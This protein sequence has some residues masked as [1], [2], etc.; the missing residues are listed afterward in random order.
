MF[1]FKS[2]KNSKKNSIKSKTSKKTIKNTST[3]TSTSTRTIT[4]ASN[5]TSNSTNKLDKYR[6]PVNKDITKIKYWE[7]PNR[8]HFHNWILDN[9]SQ[10]EIS[11]TKNNKNKYIP[12]LQQHFTLTNF[13][14]IARDYLQDESPVRGVFLY[15]GLGSGKT[16]TGI[17]ISEAILS[18]KKVVIFSK[19][20]LEANWIKEIRDC[21]ADYVKNHNY[22]VFIKVNIDDL[23]TTSLENKKNRS[24]SRDNSYSNSRGGGDSSRGGGDSSRGSDSS[25]N[26]DNND[27]N[28]TSDNIL[29]LIDELGIPHSI[30]KANGC[31]CLVDFT[32]TT[33]NFNDLTSDE[34]SKLDKQIESMVDERFEFLHTD[35]AI[36]A[37]LKPELLHNKIIIW[38][39]VHNLGN[40]MTAKSENAKKY[41]DMFMNAKNVKIMFLSGT[42]IINRIFEITKIYNILRGY[43]NVLQVQFK[44]TFDINIDYDKLQ[45]NLKKNKYIDQIIINKSKKSINISKNP[46][47]F[48]TSPDNKGILY[49]PDDNIDIDKFKED[50]TKIIQLLG[51]KFNITST[52]ETCFPEDEDTFEQLF[53]NSELNKIKHIDLIKKRI[54]GLTSYYDYQDPKNYPILLKPINIIQV[55]MSEYQFGTYEKFRHKEIEKDKQ[56]KRNSKNEDD[57]MSKSTFRIKSRLA[58]TF[59]FPEEIGNPYDSKTAEAYL[60]YIDKLDNNLDGFSFDVEKITE[61]KNRDIEAKIKE[62]YAKLLEQDKA[63]YLDINNGSLAKYSPK[64]LAMINNINKQAI[65]GKIFVYSFFRS[66]IGLNSF[67]YALLQTNKWEP[68]RIKKINKQWEMDTSRDKAG[69]GAGAGAGAQTKY[70]FIFYTGNENSD[71]LE[72][73][74][75]IMNSEWANLGADCVNLITQLKEIHPNNYNGEIIKMLM[76]TKKGAEGLDLKE[77]RFIHIMEPYWQPVLIDQVIGRG[78]RNKSHLT[79]PQIDRNVDV[80]V[81]M[82]TI[83]PNLAKKISYV[84]VRNDTYKYASTLLSDKFNKVV[85]SDEYLYLTSERKKI[86]SNEFQKIMKDSAFDCTL[87]YRDNKL[88]PDNKNLVCIDYNTKN[89][90]EYIYTPDINDTLDGINNTTHEKIVTVKYG[91]FIHKNKKYY[92]N[93]TPIVTLVDKLLHNNIGKMYIYDENLEGKVRTPKPVGFVEIKNGK[94]LYLFYGKKKPKKNKKKHTK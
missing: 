47:N 36:G 15:Y 56:I 58:C 38:D 41:Y 49:K 4:S 65:H 63:K 61:M 50:I 24:V 72:I 25:D 35:G 79:L 22:W 42:P 82:A 3:S 20:S 70:K 75:K 45:Y 21:G 8:K 90:D 52:V 88:N 17:T 59:A 89:R 87:N 68:F 14:R 33:S 48:I 81:Y 64:Y 53:Y 7:L 6:I 1:F 69:A 77:I 67:S 46:D 84:D 27:T 19:T 11:N 54:S 44:S 28:D 12:R 91:E 29:K 34:R 93:I 10:Y 57:E 26:N 78:V 2:N 74:R 83:L 51:Y 94:N 18:K 76:T 73:Y 39:E 55:P 62:G 9:F 85:T 23:I 92:F 40:T 86:V 31:V 13:Q 16:C 32:N 60:E 43:M 37:K 71:M 5:R 80:Y 66:L 30:I